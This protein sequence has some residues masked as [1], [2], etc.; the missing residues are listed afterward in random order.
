[1]RLKDLNIPCQWLTSRSR[2]KLPDMLED[3]RTLCQKLIQHCRQGGLCDADL[4]PATDVTALSPVYRDF[5]VVLITNWQK[6]ISPIPPAQLVIDTINAN[7]STHHAYTRMQAAQRLRTLI[8]ILLAVIARI[9]VTE[10]VNGLSIIST[11][12]FLCLLLAIVTNRLGDW[13][14]TRFLPL[15]WLHN[16]RHGNDRELRVWLEAVTGAYHGYQDGK[17][18]HTLHQQLRHLDEQE[19]LAGASYNQQKQQTINDWAS[20]QTYQETIRL[21]RYTDILPLLDLLAVGLPVFFSLS[22]PV[23]QRL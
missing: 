3:V 15:C 14:H 1:M 13:C 5:F 22:V 20:R 17:T 21:D 9:A 8:A 12:D 7:R 19:L 4:I 10:S 23:L 18:S 2:D 16:F 6:G 11:T